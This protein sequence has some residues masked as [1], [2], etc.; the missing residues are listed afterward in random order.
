MNGWILYAVYARL[1][2]EEEFYSPLWETLTPPEQR[3]WN[4]LAAQLVRDGWEAP[5][6]LKPA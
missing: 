2:E 4:V 5:G 1:C 6:R 3:V